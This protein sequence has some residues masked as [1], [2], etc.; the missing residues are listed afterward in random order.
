M[1]RRKRLEWF[2]ELA[3]LPSF[4]FAAPRLPQRMALRFE[5]LGNNGYMKLIYLSPCH[6]S[7]YALLTVATEYSK[8]R[9]EAQHAT[10]GP[11]ADPLEGI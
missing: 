8:I 3:Q 5:L 7:P 9:L 2:A 4:L 1:T 11:L 6:R 10:S